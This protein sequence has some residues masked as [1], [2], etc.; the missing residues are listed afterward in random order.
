MGSFSKRL[1]WC[2]PFE[3]L[4]QICKKQNIPALKLTS[5]PVPPPI[6]LSCLRAWEV[7]RNVTSIYFGGVKSLPCE[8][9]LCGLCLVTVVDRLVQDSV[10][11]FAKVHVL[12]FLPCKMANFQGWGGVT[13]P[14]PSLSFIPESRWGW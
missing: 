8:N 3:P 6:R 10:G 9:F 4:L 1:S 7:D 2:I 13:H 12:P 5:M 11:C 14:I